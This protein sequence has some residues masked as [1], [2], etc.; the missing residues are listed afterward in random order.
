MSQPLPLGVRHDKEPGEIARR[1]LFVEC[2]TT[3]LPHTAPE[4]LKT[5]FRTA[6]A[7]FGF[8][9]G[10]GFKGRLNIAAFDKEL[11]AAS[12]ACLE[13]YLAS[14]AQVPGIR[15]VN[16]H[17]AP[18]LWTDRHQDED[19]EPAGEY[20]ILIESLRQI[21]D[22]ATQSNLT[23]TVENNRA[24]WDRVP[25]EVK[26]SEVD[27]RVVR[28]Y[29]GTTAGEW[30]QIWRDVARDNVGL[31]L[32]TSHATT[33]VHRFEDLEERKQALY[34]Y[35]AEPRALKHIHWNDND[36]WNVAGRN[37]RH[38]AVGTSGLGDEFNRAIRA[39]KGVSFLLEHF[40]GWEVLDGEREYIA[41]L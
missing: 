22:Q 40:H 1:E 8:P 21:A 5:L 30:I 25:D 20:A 3:M 31:C 9:K 34:A 19:P 4:D 37:D 23:I 13:E 27:R 35:L 28:E 11:R 32:D 2:R 10:F 12:L 36:P 14:S 38:L 6:H 7:P 16:M 39:L 15:L 18:R 26:F 17:A 33:A 24:Y 29:F 41:K